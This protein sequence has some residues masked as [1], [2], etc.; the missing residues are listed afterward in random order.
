LH[1][2]LQIDLTGTLS[3]Q[4]TGG[5]VII[6]VKLSGVDLYSETDDLSQGTPLPVGPGNLE[7]KK[8]VDIPSIAPAVRSSSDASNESARSHLSYFST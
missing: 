7:F 8:S 3:Q 4:V 2:T 5:Q 6:S 1:L